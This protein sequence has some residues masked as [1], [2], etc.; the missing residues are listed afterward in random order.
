MTF[1]KGASLDDPTGLFNA[2]LEGNTRRAIDFREGDE[3]D[4][5]ALKALV[6]RPWTSTRPR[7]A[8]DR[9]PCGRLVRRERATADL[10]GDRLIDGDRGP[11]WHR[12]RRVH[13]PS[14]LRRHAA[15]AARRRAR[16]GRRRRARADGR[17]RGPDGRRRRD[18]GGDGAGRAAQR[19]H[20]RRPRDG[21]V[22]GLAVAAAAVDAVC[23]DPPPTSSSSPPTATGSSPGQD[24]ARV[25]APPAR[26][27]PP[28][29][30]RSTCCATSRASPR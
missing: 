18:L 16:P 19:G 5:K 11:A 7:P 8:A 21:I 29:A 27:S 12:G 13:V 20:V 28:S 15:A 6:V 17:R 2:S 26:S 25:T 30:P 9:R 3:V 1:A 10:A 23:G 14:P 4:E 22:A 24:V